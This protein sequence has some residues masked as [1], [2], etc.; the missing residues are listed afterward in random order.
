MLAFQRNRYQT[1]KASVI[2]AAPEAG[3]KYIALSDLANE[4]KRKIR[5]GTNGAAGNEVI[6][7]GNGNRRNRIEA[8]AREHVARGPKN[9]NAGYV[10]KGFADLA[11]AFVDGLLIFADTRVVAITEHFHDAHRHLA[12]Q[13]EHFACVFVGD[14]RD[15]VGDIVRVFHG[16]LEIVITVGE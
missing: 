3:C 6:A 14:A 7:R 5:L 4:R 13:V 15:S 16:A 1:E 2:P 11:Q 10:R 9:R 12:V 8:V